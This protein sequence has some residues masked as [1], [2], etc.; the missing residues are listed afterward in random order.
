MGSATTPTAEGTASRRPGGRDRVRSSLMQ[1]K[2]KSCLLL[3]SDT[4]A[5]QPLLHLENVRWGIASWMGG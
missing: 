3:P 4:D 5:V 2:V 1:G